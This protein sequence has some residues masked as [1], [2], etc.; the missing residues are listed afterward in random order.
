MHTR[1]LT[2]PNRRIT[3]SANPTYESCIH[4]QSVGRVTLHRPDERGQGRSPTYAPHPALARG[5]REAWAD[6]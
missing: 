1:H 4:R 2:V 6:A 3:P 5:D